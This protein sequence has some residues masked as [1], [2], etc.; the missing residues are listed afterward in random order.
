MLAKK[1]AE[2][3]RLFEENQKG[4]FLF[5][6]PALQLTLIDKITAKRDELNK[7]SLVKQTQEAIESARVQLI[8]REKLEI[9]ARERIQKKLAEIENQRKTIPEQITNQ[10]QVVADAQ[11]KANLVALNDAQNAAFNKTI[12]VLTPAQATLEAEQKRLEVLRGQNGELDL[13]QRHL[14]ELQK[15]L[16]SGSVDANAASAIGGLLGK[17]KDQTSV[18]ILDLKSKLEG[19]RGAAIDANA[20]LFKTFDQQQSISAVGKLTEAV[21]VFRDA[22]INLRTSGQFKIELSRINAEP[23]K[24]NFGG[25]VDGPNGIDAINTQLTRGEYV[26]DATNSSKFFSQLRQISSGRAPS[27]TSNAV[28][29]GG[30][31]IHLTGSGNS[32]VDA[33]AIVSEIQ[34]LKARGVVS[35]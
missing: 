25:I 2:A 8:E 33:R 1:A 18:L 29:F 19:M 10:E 31:N 12:G 26:V 20:E 24:R 15:Q 9:E 30:V 22:I 4:K 3:Q 34:R 28:N 14:N 16:N 7:L 17:N 27:S 6:D 23:I 13:Q 5:G 32:K 11:K 35:I 21:N